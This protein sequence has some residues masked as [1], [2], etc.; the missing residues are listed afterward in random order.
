MLYGMLPNGGASDSGVIFSMDTLGHNYKV[1]HDFGGTGGGDPQGSLTLTGNILYGMAYDGGKYD[2]GCIFSIDTLGNNFT[3]M[4]DFNDT[5][6]ENP[7]GDLLL[8]G[9]VLYGMTYYGGI[10][11]DSGCAFSINTDGSN[12]KVLNY[13]NIA[14]GANPRGDL[15]LSGSIL[16]GMTVN[17]GTDSDGVIFGLDTSGAA[18]S[19]NVLAAT[20]GSITIY[21][22]P[23]NGVFTINI[24]N[25]VG[26][27][28]D[29]YNM[30]GEKIY[31][32]ELNANTTQINL[33]NQTSGIYLC[34]I[35]KQD[36]NVVG[37]GKIS[38]E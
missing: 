34:R 1:I 17:G 19:I 38:I 3:D 9:N 36:G 10:Q 30:L 24:K 7:F 20:F 4:H 25:V 8:A 21:P 37:I 18:T 33:G 11:Y 5:A 22:N 28:I 31:Q 29:I 13:F 32:S 14:E 35:L 23:S 12:Y 27:T 26:T 16:Y 15:I 2:D 6:G